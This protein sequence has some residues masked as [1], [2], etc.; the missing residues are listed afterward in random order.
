MR[1]YDKFLLALCAW[2]EAS[3]QGH[4][5][6]LAVMN[7]IRNRVRKGW[8]SWQKVICGKNQFTSMSVPGDPQTVRFPAP[9]DAVWVLCR[10]LADTVYA[11]GAEDNT[12]GALYYYNP[13]TATSRWFTENVVQKG[14]LVATIR[15]HEFWIV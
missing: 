13:R 1:D 11:G 2:R 4:D 3:N 14:K 12:H 6:L 15:D 8:G 7:V 10:S 5:G 9:D